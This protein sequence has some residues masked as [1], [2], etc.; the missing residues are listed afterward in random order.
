M[1]G[2]GGPDPSPENMLQGSEYVF[3]PLKYQILSF[4]TVIGFG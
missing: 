2:V 4:K 1:G 3:D